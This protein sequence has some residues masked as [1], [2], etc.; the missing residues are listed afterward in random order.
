MLLD[1]IIAK[2]RELG[3]KDGQF[4]KR[5]GVPRS[6]WQLTRSRRVPLGSRVAK[7]A[8]TAFPELTADTLIFLLSDASVLAGAANSVAVPESIAS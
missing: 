8:Q 5:L 4:A 3:I 7:A 6:T 1:K 2:Q